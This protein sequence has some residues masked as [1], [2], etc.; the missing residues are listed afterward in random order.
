[1]RH[2]SLRGR[3]AV[4]LALLLGALP[5]GTARAQDAPERVSARREDLDS[6]RTVFLARERSFLPDARAAFERRIAALRDSVPV[7]GDE[8]LITRLAA[9]VATAGNAHTR[10]YLLRNRTALRRYPL[11]VWWFGDG[12]YVVR[13]HEAQRD[14]LGGRIVAIAGR[15]TADV[16]ALVAPLYAGNA[17]WARY[18]STYTLTSPE[19]LRGLGLIDSSGMVQIDIQTRTG[20]RVRRTIEPLPLE[21]TNDPTEAW[22]DLTPAHPGRGGPWRS[23]LSADTTRLPLYLQHPMRNYWFEYL[24]ADRLLYVSYNRSQDDANG[25]TTAAFGERL[26]GEIAAR[27][28]RKI[29]VDLRFNTGGNLDLA[30]GLFRRL[31]A[32][33]LARER[34]RLFVITGRATFSAGLYQAALLRETSRAVFVGE[35]V[36]DV[37]DFWSEGG[38]I[39]LPR[40]RLTVHFAD[41]FHS[42][43]TRE[44]PER[45]PYVRDLSIDG[46]LLDVPVELTI[47]QYL[48]GRDAALDAVRAYR[49]AR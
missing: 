19:I 26:L 25:E 45:R 14:L 12:L 44:Y 40:S 18:I 41:R 36:G 43:S 24:P 38:N 20:T 13:A 15:R 35:P 39:V 29:V 7:L 3:V 46:P 49:A 23:A 10:L 21:R 47:D 27:D 9:A 34:G 30:E 31:G 16:A 4:G 22:W 37:L 6:V 5:A 32:L 48:A 33:P 8:A 17:S 2:L 11:R 42:Y 28:P 1:M